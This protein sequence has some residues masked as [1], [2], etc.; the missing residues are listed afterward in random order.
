MAEE[1][2]EERIS[3]EVEA[4]FEM[5]EE[6][7]L[8]EEILNTVKIKHN[9]LLL[10]DEEVKAEDEIESRIELEGTWN[11]HLVKLTLIKGIDEP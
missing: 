10:Q 3:E 4:Q 8:P 1:D 9:S 5:P 11:L 6:Q 2:T 7:A